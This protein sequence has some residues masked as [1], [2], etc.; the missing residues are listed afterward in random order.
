MQTTELAKTG[1]Q[2]ELAHHEPP[3]VGQMLM[4]MMEKGITQESTGAVRE[5]VQ[6]RREIEADEAKKA[7]NR[8][9]VA[10]QSEIPRVEATKEVPNKDG[11]LRYTFAPFEGIMRQVSPLLQKHGFAV[12]F[13]TRMEG[14]RVVAIGELMHVCGHSTK[15]EFGARLGS[16]PPGS[17]EAQGDGAAS[18]YAKRFCLCNMLNII[19]A[20]IDNDARAEGSTITPDQAEDLYQRVAAMKIDMQKFMKWA[21]GRGPESGAFLAHHFES[22]PSTRYEQVNSELM[23]KEAAR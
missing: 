16:G 20:G 14:P 22:I 9:F 3:N 8:A 1:T 2:H 4:M 15:H 7:Y 5:L 11:T 18:T 12:S 6:M 13:S 19:V 21:G 10:L 23:R 17:S